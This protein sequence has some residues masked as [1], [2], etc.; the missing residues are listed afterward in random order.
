MASTSNRRLETKMN[1]LNQMLEEMTL[2]VIAVLAVALAL[3][4]GWSLLDG[5]HLLPVIQL[6]RVVVVQPPR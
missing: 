2:P 1:Q 3:V 5:Q 4:A 6:E